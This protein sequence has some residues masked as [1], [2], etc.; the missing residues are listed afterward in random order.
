MYWPNLKSVA[1]PVPGIIA[2]GVLGGVANPPILGRGS[3]KGWG[4]VPFERALVSS[5]RSSIVTFPL[6]LRVSDIAAFVLHHATFSHPTSSFSQ[7][8]PCFTRS[9]WMAFGVR[10]AKLLGKLSVQLVSKISN[11]SG[12][13]PPTSLADGQTDDAQSVPARHPRGPPFPQSTMFTAYSV[14]NSVSFRA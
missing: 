9:R 8:Y 4:M 5:Y 2:I 6:S 3:R 13:D 1:L 14:Q 12:H 10:R 11:L 7:I